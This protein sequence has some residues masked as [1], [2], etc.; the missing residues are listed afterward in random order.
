MIDWN[1]GDKARVVSDNKYGDGAVDI[2]IEFV[3][4][5]FREGS[6]GLVLLT[7]AAT[8]GFDGFY[9]NRCERMHHGERGGRDALVDALKTII[10][11]SV[12]ADR[13]DDIRR[14]ATEA[15]ATIAAAPKV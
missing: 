14:I 9:A 8:R 4:E 6:D 10:G 15:L 13:M 1:I 5:G 7:G 11:L 2:G 3:V 12:Y